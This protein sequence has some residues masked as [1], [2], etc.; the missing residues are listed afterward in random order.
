VHAFGDR[1][2]APHLVECHGRDDHLHSGAAEALLACG[3]FAFA[4]I[5]TLEVGGQH[6]IA[7]LSARAWETVIGAVLGMVMAKLIIISRDCARA[8]WLKRPAAD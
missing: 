3:A 6:S 8:S 2:A 7:T 4:L 1:G 5:V